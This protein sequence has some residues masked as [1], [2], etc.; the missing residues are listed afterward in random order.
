MAE[1]AHAN[2]PQSQEKKIID[3]EVIGKPAKGIGRGLLREIRELS[4]T[5]AIN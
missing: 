5:Q 1:V 4:V 3:K 2:S